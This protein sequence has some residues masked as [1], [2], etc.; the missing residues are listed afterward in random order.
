MAKANF[1]AMD[2]SA[3]YSLLSD[4]DSMGVVR[5]IAA[6]PGAVHAAME[7]NEPYLVSRAV[8]AICQSYNKFYYGQRITGVDE[9]LMK[10][11]LS[12]TAAAAQVIKTGLYLVGLEAPNRM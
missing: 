2:A 8:S 12:L 6:F 1:T 5:A 9:A 11:R 4:D 7:N 10:A 3:D